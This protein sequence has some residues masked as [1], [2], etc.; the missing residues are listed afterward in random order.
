MTEF[1]EEAF[2]DKQEMWGLNPAKSTV[3]TKDFFVEQ[4]V[5]SVLIPGIGYGRNAQIFR[6]NGMTVTGIEIS[7][8][9]IE[10]GK[11]HFGNEMKIYHG[12]VTEMPFDNNLYDGIFC[13]GLIYLLDKSERTKLIQDCYNQL[14]ENGFMVFTAITKQAVT[15][16][17]GTNIGNDRFEMFGGVKIFFY[18]SETIAEEFG[19]SGLFEITKVTENYPFHLIKCKKN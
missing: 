14:T 9:A 3:L 12:S 16:G 6:D 10:L 5:K 13:Y 15:Y 2:K 18:D 11:K 4:K 19:K 8:T 1:W 17:Q 7:E